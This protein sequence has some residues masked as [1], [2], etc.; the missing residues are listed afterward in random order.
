MQLALIPAAGV[1]LA[2]A[3]LIAVTPVAPSASGRQERAVELASSP[4]TNLDPITEW[5]NTI[6]GAAVNLGQ[7]GN[8][9]LADPLPVLSQVLH[10]QVGFADTVGTNLASLGDTLGKIV[11]GTA[12]GIG[13]AGQWHS[14]R[15]HQRRGE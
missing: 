4:V 13:S 6:D 7:I 3:S 1:A 5:I 14:I 2:S 10:N 11:P 9:I 12:E 15:A 8:E